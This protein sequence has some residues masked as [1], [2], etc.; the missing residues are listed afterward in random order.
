MENKVICVVVTYNR[1]ELLKECIEAL[2]KQTYKNFEILIIDNNSTD[3][4]RDYIQDFISGERV[5]YVNTNKNI[6]GAGGFNF[7]IKEAYKIGCDYVWMMDDDTIAKDDSLEKLMDADRILNGNYGFL[8]STTLWTDGT[9]CVM[10]KQKVQKDWYDSSDLLKYGLL[11]TYY[12]TFV[13]FFMKM[14]TAIDVGLPVKEFFIW[15]DDVEYT[16]RI[17]KKY[18]CYVAGQSQVVHKI[19]DNNGSNIAKENGDRI[20]RYKFAYRNECFI[21]RENGI[22]GRL[23][24]FAKVNYNIVRVLFTKNKSKLKKIGVIIGSSIK[25][26]FFRPKIEY[27]REESKSAK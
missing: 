17:S 3:G 24:Q 25:G 15:G 13:S 1:K 27:L 14:Q 6:G 2:L 26:I 23:R 12:A 5:R 21:A 7:G 20:S 9:P 8:S 22:K 19:K 11:R 18:N 10:N 16:N 4:T